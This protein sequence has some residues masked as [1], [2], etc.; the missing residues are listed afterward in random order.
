MSNNAMIQ[1]TKFFKAPPRTV[2]SITT[3]SETAKKDIIFKIRQMRWLPF[4]N[5]ACSLHLS[6]SRTSLKTMFT[7]L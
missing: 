6:S 3:A 7:A 4:M 1:Y 2:C 5:R